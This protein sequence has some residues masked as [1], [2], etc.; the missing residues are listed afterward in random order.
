MQ[1]KN[2]CSYYSF[3]LHSQ[4]NQGKSGVEAFNVE[5]DKIPLHNIK[6]YGR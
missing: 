3:M 4:L 2:V 5:K 6:K 1:T